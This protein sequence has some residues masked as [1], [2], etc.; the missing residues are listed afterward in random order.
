MTDDTARID[1]RLD[2]LEG[3]LDKL[4]ELTGDIKVL[5]RQQAQN[6]ESLSRAFAKIEQRDSRLD[7]LHLKVRGSELKLGFG[8]RLWWLIA[9]AGIGIAA[10]FLRGTGA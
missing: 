7:E 2:R 8:E 10:Y 1:A 5:Q 4:V 6:S 3:K 9:T